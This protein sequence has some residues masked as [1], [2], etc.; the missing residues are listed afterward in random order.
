ME[1]NINDQALFDLFNKSQA[2]FSNGVIRLVSVVEHAKL[3]EKQFTTDLLCE[4]AITKR[5][6]IKKHRALRNT[7][8]NALSK[9]ALEMNEAMAIR[10]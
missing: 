9:A 1:T 7:L 3:S 10:H 6:D 4:M 2:R 8:V 5:V